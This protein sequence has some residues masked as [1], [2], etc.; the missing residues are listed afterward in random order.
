M[1]LVLRSRHVEVGDTDFDTDFD[2]DVDVAVSAATTVGEVAA[3]LAAGSINAVSDDGLWV[4]ARHLPPQLSVV[5]AG[6]LDG[7]TV[8]LAPPLDLDPLTAT[9]PPT[10]GAVEVR[11]V[12]GLIAGPAVTLSPGR[13]EVGQPT[14]ACGCHH[15]PS[16][17]ATPES[18]W[19]MTAP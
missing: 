4:G 8:G 19:A 9:A 1:R 5:D 14:P 6:L 12:A 16:A 10:T 7:M 2:V 15:R 13:H 17:P 18:R 11:V 3:A